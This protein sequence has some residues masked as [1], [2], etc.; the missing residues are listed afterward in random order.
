MTSTAN[1]GFVTS[2]RGG[3]SA[4]EEVQRQ[5][6]EERAAP[7][8]HRQQAHEDHNRVDALPARTCP[9]HVLE[10][11]PEGEFVE[12]E[13]SPDAVSDRR[14]AGEKAG[15]GAGFDQPDVA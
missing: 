1:G 12:R 3:F 9:V 11:E 6:A 4:P 5:L 7:D 13:G 14:D 2:L 15:R 8:A 10:V